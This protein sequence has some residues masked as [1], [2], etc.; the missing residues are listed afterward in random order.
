MFSMGENSLKYYK[1]YRIKELLPGVFE[2]VYKTYISY[3]SK[4]ST[5]TDDL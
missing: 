2:G 5:I 1:N 4:R 3:S